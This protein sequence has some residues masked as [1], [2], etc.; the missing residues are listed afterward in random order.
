MARL[1]KSEIIP[2]LFQIFIQPIIEPA[3]P[4]HAVL[5]FQHP[6]VF[7]GEIEEF[8]VE[9]AKDGGVV[10]LHALREADAVVQSAVDDEDGRGPFVDE[11][12]G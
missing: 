10:G 5:R 1:Y 9:A 12:V 8:R 4:K 2:K 11:E 7:V 3:L 6:V